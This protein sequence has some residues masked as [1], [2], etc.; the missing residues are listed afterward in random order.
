LSISG[1][2]LKKRKKQIRKTILAYFTLSATAIAVNCIYG[3]FGHDVHSASMTWMFLYPLL[4]GTLFYTLVY[5]LIPDVVNLKTY[6]LFYNSYNSGIAALTI[7]N[8]LKGILEI[9]G[10][11]SQY[12][13][14]FYIAGSL[15]ILLGLAVLSKFAAHRRKVHV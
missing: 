11:S 2:D 12:V 5:L 4:G 14:Y 8:F 13:L 1:T 10:T 9:A 7:G 6:R 3:V 15:F